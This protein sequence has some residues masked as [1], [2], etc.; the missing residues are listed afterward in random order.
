MLYTLSS[1]VF[2]S[3]PSGLNWFLCDEFV[4]AQLILMRNNPSCKLASFF[5]W[6]AALFR[7]LK[8]FTYV[9]HGSICSLAS[10]PWGCSNVSGAASDHEMP[11]AAPGPSCLWWCRY[12][13]RYHI[14]IWPSMQRFYSNYDRA[15]IPFG[16]L[17]INLSLLISCI[18]QAFR[19][20]SLKAESCIVD[21]MHS[22]SSDAITNQTPSG[23]CWEQARLCSFMLQW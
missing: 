23:N 13:P 5:A 11:Q 16:N 18:P 4:W 1:S 6:L 17:V 20:G 19:K 15:E 21:W 14:T 9:S 10:N 22:P 8:H 12:L 2:I 7:Q 3:L